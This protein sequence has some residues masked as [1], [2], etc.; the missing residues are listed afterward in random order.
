MN[1][2]SIIKIF[3][4][5]TEKTLES[6]R[7][8]RINEIQNNRQQKTKNLFVWL[9][10]AEG[11]RYALRITVSHEMAKSTYKPSSVPPYGGDDHLSR[12][13]VTDGL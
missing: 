4:I 8:Y 11:K 3:N 9:Y 2:Y 5:V 10:K 6:S 1:E 13:A 12:T 7:V